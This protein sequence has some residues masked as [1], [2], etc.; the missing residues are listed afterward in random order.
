MHL[1]TATGL[2]YF[3]W[4]LIAVNGAFA[5][6]V[7]LQVA[8]F[9]RSQLALRNHRELQHIE[10][11]LSGEGAQVCGSCGHSK[12][13]HWQGHGHCK[14]KLDACCSSCNCHGFY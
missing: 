8:V 4:A 2:D 14:A 11:I 13:I 10:Y 5:L 1:P 6:V 7:L 3:G 9:V 12:N